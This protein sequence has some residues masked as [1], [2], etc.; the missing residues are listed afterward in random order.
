MNTRDYDG[1]LLDVDGTL[2]DDGD[3]PRPRTVEA[4]A[5]AVESGVTVMLA[6]GRSEIATEPVLRELGL[7]TPAIVFNGAG[8][9][10]PVKGRFLEERVLSNRTRRRSV[11]FALERGLPVVAM[12]S[13]AKYAA[14]PKDEL[15]RS[16]FEGLVGL[17]FIPPEDLPELDSVIRVTIYSSLHGDSGELAREL[18]AAVRQPVYLTDFPLS[19]LASHRGSPMNVVDVQPPCRGK[20]EALRVLEENFGI[21]PGRVVAV[22]DATNDIPMVRAAGLGCAMGNGMPELHAH[23]DRVLGDNGSDALGELIEELFLQ[24]ST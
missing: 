11:N 24:T 13:G 7:E 3:R 9:W 8:L 20:A 14:G 5:R 10:C 18:E 1:L 21:P 6:T 4:L 16:A 19:A 22:G 17:H 23:A 12:C 15:E 2:M